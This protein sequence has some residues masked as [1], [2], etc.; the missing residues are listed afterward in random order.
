[1]S[2]IYQFIEPIIAKVMFALTIL[3]LALV[4]IIVQYLQT[5]NGF[6]RLFCF[7]QIIDLL[8]ILW[9]IF[10]FERVIYLIFCKRRTWKSVI[11]LF[12]IF[13][14]PPLRLAIKRCD[15][16]EYIWWNNNW[17]L[18]NG[19]LYKQIEKKFLYP[20]LIISLIMIP[21]W[22]LEIFYP[23][24]VSSLPFLYHLIN[25][26]NALIWGVFAAE[27][28]IMISIAKDKTQYL[29]K[30]WLEFFIIILPLLALTRFIIIAK[31]LKISKSTYLIWFVKLQGILNIYRTRSVI[32][33]IIRILI[34]IDIVKRF[35]Q[36]KN[37]H[38]YL[39]ILQNKLAK[40]EEEIAEIK[41]KI[42]EVKAII[43]KP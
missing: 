31:Y 15:A 40:H 42:E 11:T 19:K 9:P 12:V 14:I 28:I 23:A 24:K 27:F 2:K 26:G 18:V 6:Q 43:N 13:L 3:F 16:Q 34:I 5:D 4:A 33:R 41:A 37:P 35:Y 25:F 38:K 30:H 32:N 20:I 10:F 29:I 1:M 7:Q 21:F 8:V 22:V 36:R 39:L 17:Q